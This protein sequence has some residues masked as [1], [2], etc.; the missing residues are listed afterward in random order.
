MGQ[1]SE[2]NYLTTK[3]VARLCRVS[4]ATVKRWED[5][6]LLKSERTSGQHR[7]FRAEEVARFQREQ[8]L[9]QKT[10]H[11]DQS[12]QSSLVRRKNLACSTSTLFDLL[13]S[14][15]EEE[16][17]NFM[18]G[19]FLQGTELTDIFD[20]LLSPAMRQI[21]ELWYQGELSV[22]QEHLATRAAHYAVHKL[23]TSLPLPE[24][25][26]KTAF[27]AAMEGDLHE[28]PS[29]LAQVTIENEGWEVMNFGA[30]TPLF[31]LNEEV[32]QYS[33]RAVCLSAT[34]M[35]ELERL[36]REYKTLRENAVKLKVPVILGGKI[37]E[38]DH[39]RRRFPAELY[40]RSFGEVAHFIERLTE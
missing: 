7:R 12:V 22:S 24:M 35:T 34:Y 14:G 10:C 19:S 36:S 38:D 25:K 23:R 20:N 1:V 31:S 16:T 6:G 21:G 32:L 4:D 26:G 13:V 18:I 11:G 15:C 5:A 33:P 9:G 29:Y 27:C 40:A 17:A 8:G 3:E 37:F 30:N 28:L 39:I 2:T